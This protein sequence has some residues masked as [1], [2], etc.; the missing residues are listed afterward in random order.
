MK[1]TIFVLAWLALAVLCVSTAAQ[2]NSVEYWMMKSTEL[3]N[4]GSLEDSLNAIDKVLQISPENESALLNKADILRC[5]GRGDESAKA[6]KKSLEILNKTLEMNPQ[7]ASLWYGKGMALYFL[8]NDEEAVAA[9]ERAW[10]ILNQSCKKDPEN[11]RALVDNAHILPAKGRQI[12]D[13]IDYPFVDDPQMI[14]R[15]QSVDFVQ[16]IDAFNP[17]AKSAIDDAHLKE[18]TIFLKDGKING[19]KLL[20][21]KGFIIDPIQKTAS[22]YGIK[23]INGSKYLFYEWKSGDYTLRGM[24]P[25]LCVL[26]KVDSSDYSIVEPPR[27]ED[28]IDYPFVA[29]PQILGRW[30]SVDIVIKPEDFKPGK[31]NYPAGELYLKGLNISENGNISA[32]FK[33]R[34]NESDIYTWTKD[35]VLCDRNKTASQYIIREIDGTAYMFFQWKGG[36]YVLRNME[37]HYY[38][39]KK[40]D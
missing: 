36:D 6:F 29:D 26:K 8:G 21:T 15:W 10:E 17:D 33:D 35:L 37:P 12:V 31:A 1:K 3:F 4:N 13:R 22:K 9:N 2:E 7:D 5:L 16:R 20:W 18:M 34:T 27:K 30:E 14:G 39:L 23:E 11:A 32:N 40:V 19:T 25:W 28:R 38:V 24:K